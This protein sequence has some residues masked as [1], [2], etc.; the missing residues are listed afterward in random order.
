ME[1]ESSRRG[2][3]R[4]RRLMESESLR[5]HERKKEDALVKREREMGEIMTRVHKIPSLVCLS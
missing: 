4:S 1:S 5:R 2:H 3:R